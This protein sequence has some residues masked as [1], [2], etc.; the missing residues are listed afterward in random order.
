MKIF[1]RTSR[2]T[3]GILLPVAID[4]R[5]KLYQAF[6]RLAQSNQNRAYMYASTRCAF[7]R[8]SVVC[9]DIQ[10]GF[11]GDSQDAILSVA[12]AQYT[13]DLPSARSRIGLS[14]SM[15][16]VILC[17][18]TRLVCQG[19]ES[20]PKSLIRW[21]YVSV[22]ARELRRKPLCDNSLIVIE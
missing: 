16:R 10:S 4:V 14:V 21:I 15:P 9:D 1:T 6:K 2:H 7:L 13:F 19:D 17:E 11:S 22:L 3:A 12:V 5:S 8:Y 18:W 20:A